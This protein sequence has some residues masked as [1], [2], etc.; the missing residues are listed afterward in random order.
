MYAGKPEKD[1]AMLVKEYLQEF[2]N[3][4][5]DE[6][7]EVRDFLEARVIAAGKAAVKAMALYN[8]ENKYDLHWN[9]GWQSALDT[10]RRLAEQFLKGYE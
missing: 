2:D 7:K 1:L 6:S 9:A 4:F 5:E 8:F 10:V 3:S